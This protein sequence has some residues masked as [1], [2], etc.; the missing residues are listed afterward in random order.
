MSRELDLAV[1]RFAR[2]AEGV[3]TERLNAVTEAAGK[4][5]EERIG[6][7]RGA[8]ERQR[9]EALQALEDRAHTIEAGLRDR[10][11]EIAREAEAERGV[12]ESRLHDLQRRLD[13]MAARI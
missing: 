6:R 1:E 2:Q 12:L 8:L 7:T 5:I 4:R 11:R 3:L 13:E 10:L 9:D